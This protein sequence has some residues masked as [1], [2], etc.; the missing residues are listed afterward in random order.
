VI[1]TRG[2]IASGAYRS[3]ISD[4]DSSSNVLSAACPLFVPL[5][6]EGM[7]DGPAAEL[8]ARGYLE[9]LIHQHIETLVLGCTHYPLLKP[10]LA[11]VLGPTVALIDSAAETAAEARELLGN[12]DLLAKRGLA[13]E[14]RFVTSDGPQQF[15]QLGQRFLGA[16]IEDVELV[17][18]G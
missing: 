15:L 18:P 11:R 9:P 1:G 5:A 7:V 13:P 10:L 16:A 3:A 6:E 17:L 8:I 2:T 12:N 4:L 14:H